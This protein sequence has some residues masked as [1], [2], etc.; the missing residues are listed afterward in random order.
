MWRWIAHFLFWCNFLKNREFI[1][2]SDNLLMR[3]FV[4]VV[5]FLG[6]NKKSQPFWVLTFFCSKKIKVSRFGE[7]PKFH[8]QNPILKVYPQNL[9]PQFNTTIWSQNVIPL[10]DLKTWSQSLI[11][12]FDLKIWSK[13]LTPKFD[14]K[15][16]SHK[17]SPTNIFLQGNET[18]RLFA[19]RVTLLIE[20]KVITIGSRQHK[21]KYGAT[22]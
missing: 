14:S 3:V 17:C 15:M 2:T 21:I 22:E 19:E 9:I 11:P 10:I 18:V 7:H 12:L 16:W 1:S 20:D 13:N 6:H 8:P 4:P 5:D